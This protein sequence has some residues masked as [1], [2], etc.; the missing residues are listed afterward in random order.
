MTRPLFILLI[1]LL[2][3]GLWAHDHTT[4]QVD[5]IHN[6]GQ[7]ESE[8][9]YK[10]DLFGGWVFLE[11]DRLTFLFSDKSKLHPGLGE[12]PRYLVVNEEKVPNPAWKDPADDQG[13]IN[14]HAYRVHWVGANPK[15]KV[16]ATERQSYYMNYFIGND[17]GK[18]RSNVQAYRMIGYNSL[19]KN[20]DLN[21]YS[22]GSSMK[23]DYIVRKGGN[24]ADI[25]LMY[26]GVD[27]MS[28]ENNGSLRLL[29]SINE[30]YEF[31][32]YA[33]QIINGKETEVACRYR[34]EGNVVSF[35]MPDGYNTSHDLV[36]DPTLVFSTYSGSPSDNWGSSSTH[37]ADGNMFLGG[38]ALGSLYPTT[39]GAFQTSYGGGTVSNG[40]DV[41]ITKFT[42]NGS[43]RLYSTYM[44]GSSN[45]VLSSL[46]C[47]PQNELIALITTSSSNF[48]TSANGYDKS[49]NGGTNTSILQSSISFPNGSDIA[50]VKLNTAGSAL[51]G[52]TFFGG[53]GNEGANKATGLLFNYGDESRGDI[54]VDAAGNIYISSNTT[55]TNIPGTSGKAQPNNAGNYDGIIA[56]FNSNL[57]SL[58]WSTYYGGTG[59]DAAYS[60]TLDSDNNILFCGGTTS[61]NLPGVANGLNSTYRGGTADG[62][63]ARLSSNGNSFTAGTY[64]GTGAYDQA[65]IMDVD[66][67]NNVYIFGQS[68]GSYPVTQGVYS[69]TNA[70]QFV[71]KLNNNLT[72]TSYSTT[73]GTSNSFF[74]NIS[75]T[76]LLVDVCENIYAVGWGGSVNSDFQFNAGSTFGMPVTQDAYKSTTDGSDFYL[77]SLS[78]DATSLVY[79]TY[80]GETGGVGDHVDGGTSRFDKNGI[81]YQA[82]CASCGGSNN[83]PTTVG[84]YSRNNLSSNC[85]MAGV[86]FRFDLLAMQ[87]ITATAIPSSGCA[88]LTTSFTYTSTRPGVSFFW[89]FGDGNTSAQEFPSHTYTQPGTYTVKFRLSNPQ[90]CNPVDST[91]FTVTVADII[92][93]DITRTICEGGSVTIGNQTFREPGSYAVTLQN[94]QGCDSIVNLTLIV[95]PVKVTNIARTICEGESITIGNQTFSQEGN[96]TVVLQTSLGCDSTVNLALTVTPAVR[97]FL[98]VTLCEGETIGI[99]NQTFSESGEYV[100]T[101]VAAS[102]CDS[103]VTLNLTVNPEATTDIS[104]SICPGQSVTIGDQTFDATGDYTILLQTSLG[105][106]STVNLSL[107]V[108]DNIVVN[109][110][111]AICTGSSVTIGDEVFDE[112]GEFTVVLE[113]AGGCDSTV[114]L[115]LEVVDRFDVVVTETICFGDSVVI[116]DEVFTEEGEYQVDLLAQGR[117]DS[118]IYLTLIV[119][120]P[121]SS[122]IFAEICEG[123]IYTV[124]NQ[125]FGEGGDYEIVLTGSNGCDSTVYLLLLVTDIPDIIATAEPVEVD[126]GDVVQ[127]G[128]TPVGSSE[129]VSWSPAELLS[130]PGSQFPTATVTETTWFYVSVFTE[131]QCEAKDSVLVVV[132]QPEGCEENN[133]FLPNAFTPN[134]DGQNDEFRVRSVVPLE[135]MLLVIYNRWG[136]KVFETRDQ[137]FYWDGTH[138]GKPA[139]ADAYGYYFEGDCAG[140]TIKK[141][142]NITIIR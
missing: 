4:P 93:T 79:A 58:D 134:G 131:N 35:D 82:V 68:L 30:V 83:F 60:I 73:F 122:E 92:T 27:G 50:I 114:N 20:I 12:N 138:N 22:Q 52:S 34:L 1:I 66:K 113:A 42:A 46:Y 16:N 48:P 78:R 125:T 43:T 84:A 117:C 86:K 139:A 53:S 90:D 26:E 89:D 56:K 31:K 10:A 123:E 121:S 74:I 11:K 14:N 13:V 71:H 15:A 140:T 102:G 128:V 33:Y 63:V 119:N 106:D 94:P 38:I 45:E 39:V 25:R 135:R 99:G 77:I 24:V 110:D 103:I 133:I 115:T 49:F 109:L 111:L 137:T 17:Q 107:L 28:I 141:Q 40:T 105:C 6:S 32:P 62:F 8:V 18:W 29:T 100:V 55:S 120:F 59:N 97:S 69:N 67:N 44:G 54:A 70:R 64:L 112:S 9:L 108:T 75:P 76:A 87:I 104:L 57:S 98:N 23:S 3:G 126:A 96:F 95:N 61:T 132:R 101:L 88:P 124:G 118:I 2:T 41:V 36:I 136:E 7:W 127:L 142:G 65:Y 37:D 129:I 91:T 85:N 5:Y 80:F 72:T 51:V 116:G 130:D 21:I 81:V 47:T 19:Y